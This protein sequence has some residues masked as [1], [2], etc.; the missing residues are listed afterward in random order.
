MIKGLVNRKPEIAR[1]LEAV[2]VEVHHLMKSG[3]Q[4]GEQLKIY[5]IHAD[6]I[7]HTDC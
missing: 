1:R 3:Q 7:R 4:L 2:G 5:K 6:K